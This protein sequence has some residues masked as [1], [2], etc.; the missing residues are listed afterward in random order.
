[1][2]KLDDE[3]AVQ[4]SDTDPR[5]APFYKMTPDFVLDAFE[6]LGFL[7][8]ARIYSLNSYENRVYQVGIED[9][10]PLIAKFYRPNRWSHAQI[11]EEHAFSLEL[12]INDVPIVMP[13][14][15]EGKTLF[16]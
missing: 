4:H 14:E 12:A 11:L 5:E 9:G 13:L 10:E 16:H 1:M 15:V 8:D 6:S 3:V 2:N 7:S